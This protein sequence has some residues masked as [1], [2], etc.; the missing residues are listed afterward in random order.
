MAEGAEAAEA[1]TGVGIG[2]LMGAWAL[3]RG[4]EALRSTELRFASPIVAVFGVNAIA[5]GLEFTPFEWAGSFTIVG[6]AFTAAAITAWRIGSPHPTAALKPAAVVLSI[7]ALILSLS[8]LPVREYVVGAVLALGAEAVAAGLVTRRPYLVT[9][10]PVAALAAWFV[11][12]TAPTATLQWY[13]TPI[14]LTLLAESDIVRWARNEADGDLEQDWVAGIELHL[15]EWAGIGLLVLTP[16]IQMFA[17]ESLGHGAIAFTSAAGLFLWALI[18]G[19]RRRAIASLVLATVTSVLWIASAGA[20]ASPPSAFFWIMIA[21]VGVSALLAMTL[22]ES[23]RSRT[24][25]LM[26][27]IDRFLEDPA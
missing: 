6:V 16:L 7:E 13:T 25:P 19:V 26:S 3:Y 21:G 27:W 9:L 17:T 1:W 20:A 8:T 24:G 10:G 2:L 22:V 18:T 15:V 11:S 5:Y 14:A 4:A 12:L 23:Y